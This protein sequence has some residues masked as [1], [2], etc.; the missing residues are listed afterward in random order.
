MVKLPLSW[1]AYSLPMRLRLSI[2][3]MISSTDS[4]TSRPGSVRPADALAVAREDVDAQL[5]FQL[6][7]GLGHP[8]LGGEQRLGGIG[9]VEILA[10]RFADEAQLMK[11]HCSF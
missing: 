10:H 1:A 8:R 11:V 9:Q 4:S 2:S 3:C 6:D 5:F 7:D